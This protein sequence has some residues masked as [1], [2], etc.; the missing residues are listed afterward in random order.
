[1]NMDNEKL[2]RASAG[3]AMA[4][5]ITVL[6]STA[7]AWAKDAYHPLNSFMNAVAWHNWITHGLADLVLFI[8]L[9]LILSRTNWVERIAPN[10][11]ISFLAVAVVV[12]GAG[13]F[14]WFAV[15]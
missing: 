8:G 7:L 13:L 6:F 15:F 12:A 14:V 3:F 11:L 5:S 2:T 1:M 10:R 4:G 9:G